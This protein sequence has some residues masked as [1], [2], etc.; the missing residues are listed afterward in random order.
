MSTITPSLPQTTV[1]APTPSTVPAPRADVVVENSKIFIPGWVNSLAEFRHWAET[2]EYPQSGWVSYLNGKIWVDASMEE[3]LSHNRVKV[4]F[5]G[6]FYV[7][8]GQHTVGSFVGDRMLLVHEPANLSTEP[9]GLFHTWE[10]VKAGRLRLIP[11][12]KAGFMVLE[13]T[14]DIV[15]EIISEGSVTKD[16]VTLRDLYWKAGIAEYWLVDARADEVRFDILRHSKDGYEPTP[17]ADGWLR[18]DILARSFRIEKSLDPL[19]LPQ[20]AV[21]VKE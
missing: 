12:K 21:Q 14:P 8:L 13:G 17:L 11:G 10:T 6:M 16:E 20:Y 7:L 1:I 4:A 2:D 3:L 19:G 18:S 9:D 15:L 5:T